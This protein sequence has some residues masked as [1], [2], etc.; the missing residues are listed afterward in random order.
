MGR[1][2][3][4]LCSNS[5]VPAMRDHRWGSVTTLSSLVRMM[6]SRAGA[7]PANQFHQH[8]HF[9]RK[10]LSLESG[11]R[12]PL[13]IKLGPERIVLAGDRHG[14]GQAGIQVV[15]EQ[16]WPPSTQ[17]EQPILFDR[18]GQRHVGQVAVRRIGDQAGCMAEAPPAQQPSQMSGALDGPAPL[19]HQHLQKALRRGREQGAPATDDPDRARYHRIADRACHQG[20]VIPVRRGHLR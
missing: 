17:I 12:D 20:G 8:G 2:R 15:L 13:Q 5:A 9:T 19:A 4:W 7:Y 3:R 16:R 14:A 1:H 18:R 6:Y 11:Y 10:R